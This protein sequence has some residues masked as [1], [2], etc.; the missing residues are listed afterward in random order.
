MKLS[1]IIPAYNEEKTIK[2]IVDKVLEVPLPQ[3]VSKEVVVVDD[4]SRDRT[5]EVLKNLP[6]D[7]RL[8]IFNHEKNQG[9]TAGILTGIKAAGGDYILIQDADLEYSPDN[10]SILLKP[11]LDGKVKVV[12]GSRFLGRKER[13]EWINEFANR[14]SNVSFNLF[15][16]HYLTDINTCYKIFPRE[17]FNKII[18][19]S[20]RFV[21][22]TELTA[23]LV[24]CGYK[25]LEV[26]IEYTARSRQE[27]KKI[28]WRTA[29]EMY[30]GII[31]YRFGRL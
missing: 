5:L 12:Y 19:T 31:Q 17:V 21:F 10:Y 16:G 26:P 22:E 25:I 1:I 29:V 2:A 7:S 28:N 13:M 20:K 4:G 27:G 24:R 18:I 30:W 14:F 15:Y 9:K 8:K 3:G 6:K 23:K 11:I